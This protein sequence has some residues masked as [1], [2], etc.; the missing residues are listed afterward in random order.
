MFIIY[1]YSPISTRT[2]GVCENLFISIDIFSFLEVRLEKK[3]WKFK[4]YYGS[5]KN[6]IAQKLLTINSLQ[7]PDTHTYLCVSRV[8]ILLMFKS[9]AWGAIHKVRTQVAGG[10]SHDES[11]SV[12]TGGGGFGPSEY[13]RI[14]T[15]YFPFLQIFSIKKK[16]END[17]GNG[18]FIDITS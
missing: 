6:Y 1:K 11:V 8:Y 17:W 2:K 10:G 4:N 3:I 5:L 16:N 7:P 9:F 13:V 15:V 18:G 14:S 12:L